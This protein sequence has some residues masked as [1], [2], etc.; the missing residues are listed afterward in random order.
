MSN[1]N[2]GHVAQR[3]ARLAITLRH[4]GSRIPVLFFLRVEIIFQ[5]M[6]NAENFRR[7]MSSGAKITDG[8]VMGPVIGSESCW[9]MRRH[10]ANIWALSSRNLED[11]WFMDMYHGLP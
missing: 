5:P 1:T 8:Q 4:P 7:T 3:L 9:G 11:E 2:I 10:L 6:A